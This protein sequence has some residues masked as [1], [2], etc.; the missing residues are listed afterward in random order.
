MRFIILI[1]L[2]SFTSISNSSGKQT[3]DNSRSFEKWIKHKR[4]TQKI[5]S[6]AYDKRSEDKNTRRHINSSSSEKQTKHKK[7]TQSKDNQHNINS[8]SLEKKTK[9]INKSQKIDSFAYEKGS[10]DKITKQDIN[11][12]SS[13]KQTNHKNTSHQI[14]FEDYEE[15]SQLDNPCPGPWCNWTQG[16]TDY[17]SLRPKPDFFNLQLRL[18]PPTTTQLPVTDKEFFDKIEDDSVGCQKEMGHFWSKGQGWKLF[19]SSFYKNGLHKLKI[20]H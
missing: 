3:E 7:R 6:N 18:R 19:C 9:H 5:G 2:F 1:I 14:R 17:L 20:Y 4:R 16:M 8:S 13:E 10:E 15:K 11:S 12:S